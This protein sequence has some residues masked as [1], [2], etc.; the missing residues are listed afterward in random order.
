MTHRDLPREVRGETALADILRY[1][2]KGERGRE[3]VCQGR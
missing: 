2:R 1:W 3:L